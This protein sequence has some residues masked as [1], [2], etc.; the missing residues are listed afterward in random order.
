M[1]ATLE[2]IAAGGRDA[3]YTGAVAEDIVGH[4]KSLGG[5]HTLDD[6][7]AAAGE[8]VDPIKASYR[9]HDVYQCPPNGQGVIALLL[10]NI[11]GPMGLDKLDPLSPERLHLCI[12]ASRLAYA[13]RDALISDPDQVEVPVEKLLSAEFAA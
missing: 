1:A 12:E 10:L 9:G 5:A 3:F 4:L 13:E 11:L 2:K 8:Y 6:F 7:A